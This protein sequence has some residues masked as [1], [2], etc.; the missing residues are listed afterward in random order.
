M[1]DENMKRPT[2]GPDSPGRRR[3][4]APR[5]IT[6]GHVRTLT[7]TGSGIQMEQ[8]GKTQPTRMP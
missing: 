7:A 6:Y 5:V 1:R 3:Y 8:A 2:T 4:T